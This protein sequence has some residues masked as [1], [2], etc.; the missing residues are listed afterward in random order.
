MGIMLLEFVDRQSSPQST[1]FHA[2]P[3]IVEFITLEPIATYQYT[4][5]DL[6]VILYLTIM[7]FS[8]MA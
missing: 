4:S 3:Y 7:N 8:E 2:L 1:I 5:V 6:S